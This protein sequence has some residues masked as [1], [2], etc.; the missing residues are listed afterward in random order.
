[1]SVT[2]SHR[3]RTLLPDRSKLCSS[4]PF[5]R[6]SVRP[7][8]VLASATTDRQLS[9]GD[10]GL[11]GRSRLRV[12]HVM[13]CTP[14]SVPRGTPPRVAP[15]WSYPTPSCGTCSAPARAALH[16][17]SPCS[18]ALRSVLQPR[19]RQ[20]AHTRGEAYPP[21]G[22]A[23]VLQGACSRGTGA[24]MLEFFNPSGGVCT[25]WLVPPNNLP[26]LPPA[27]HPTP[28]MG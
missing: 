13:E 4:H 20:R 25:L 26:P 9:A 11:W 18:G 7:L 5:C 21:A 1:M 10:C 14:P 2:L 22:G 8:C 6:T 27:P 15:G 19:A 24:K 3:R 12:P 28:A 17:P 16:R 23:G